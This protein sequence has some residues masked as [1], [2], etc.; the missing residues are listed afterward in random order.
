MM[1]MWGMK[2]IWRV[3]GGSGNKGKKEENI[4]SIYL[5]RKKKVR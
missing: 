1:M 2:N 4:K 5:T 3:E